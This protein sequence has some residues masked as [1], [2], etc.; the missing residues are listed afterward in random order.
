MGEGKPF[1]KP[2]LCF[3]EE[4]QHA[5]VEHLNSAE[6][7]TAASRLAL[8]QSTSEFNALH[9]PWLKALIHSKHA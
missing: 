3:Q 2:P 7:H 6:A 4:P 1:R 5:D 9:S 8:T